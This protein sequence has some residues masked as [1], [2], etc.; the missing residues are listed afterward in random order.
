MK[1]KDGQLNRALRF[2]HRDFA[3]VIALAYA[4]SA[5]DA[6][7]TYFAMHKSA[8]EILLLAVILLGMVPVSL[9]EPRKESRGLLAC[10]CS[11]L[12]LAGVSLLCFF[13]SGSKVL[14]FLMTGELLVCAALLILL[15]FWPNSGK[16]T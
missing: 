3:W 1:K 2:R 12:V 4:F 14:L 16:K 6:V 11:F 13:D 9:F 5:A 7:Y 15:F 10:I 8:S